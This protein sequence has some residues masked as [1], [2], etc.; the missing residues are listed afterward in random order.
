MAVN[1]SIVA[2]KVKTNPQPPG[3]PSTFSKLSSS[4][5]SLILQKGQLNKVEVFPLIRD[6]YVE[7]ASAIQSTVTPS[8]IVGQIIKLSQDN[9]A[10]LSLVL[11]SAGAPTTIDLIEGYANDAALQAVWVASNPANLAVLDSGIVA[12]GGSTQSMKVDPSTIGDEWVDTIA[13]TDLTGNSIRL[14]FRGGEISS[15][16]EIRVFI[17]DGTNTKSALLAVGTKDVWNTYT[18]AETAMVED[19]VGTTNVAAITVVGFRVTLDKAGKFSYIDNIEY[20]IPPGSVDLKLYDM[21]AT[22]P[23]SGVATLASGTQYPDLNEAN[24][25][26]VINLT[27]LAGKR[28]YVIPEFNAAIEGQTAL[29]VNNY[30]AL[31]LSYVDQDVKVY[32]T[33]PANAAQLYNNGYA[34]TAPDTVT[35]ITQI[36]TYNDINFSLFHNNAVYLIETQIDLDAAAGKNSI[37]ELIVENPSTDAI[38]DTIHAHTHPVGRTAIK[39]DLRQKPLLIAKL[40]ELEL[41][42]TD[43]ENDSVTTLALN[44]LY[45]HQPP[46]ING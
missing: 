33:N 25:A 6:E 44:A 42:Y 38:V 1:S 30:Y 18:I 43:D 17:G 36:G 35:A 32:G 10:S 14:D 22:L 13:S 21:G 7:S 2:N 24:P 19:G 27:L 4:G 15:K 3:V 9:I 40:D 46:T 29:N 12:P 37:V 45:Y 28:S 8:N 20:I 16:M 5:H 23:V 41:F 26:A 34:F 11:E 31:T 39:A